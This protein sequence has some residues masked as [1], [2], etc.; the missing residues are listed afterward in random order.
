MNYREAF[1]LGDKIKGSYVEL[2]FGKGDSARLYANMILKNEIKNRPMWIFDSFDGIPA[3]T[4]YDRSFDSTLH[5]GK[6]AR[7]IQPALDLRFDIPDTKYKVVKGYIEDTFD[8]FTDSNINVLNIDLSTYSSTKAAL[9]LFHGLV[10]KYGVVLVPLYDINEGVKAAVQDYLSEKGLV[11]QIKTTNIFVNTQAPSYLTK[12]TIYKAEA[13]VEEKRVAKFTKVTLE[14]FPSKVKEVEP[15]VYEKR[16]PSS[17]STSA[18]RDVNIEE[19]RVPKK[20]SKELEPFKDSYK[21]E[22]P[23]KISYVRHIIEGAK[24]LLNK[25]IR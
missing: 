8:Q 20:Q 18:S 3:P 15:I 11:H 17:L 21:K 13:D 10:P 19:K 2:G 4:D 22:T 7:P 12:R 23:K 16:V 25:V 9:E 6:F 1:I 24:V 5:K 14:P